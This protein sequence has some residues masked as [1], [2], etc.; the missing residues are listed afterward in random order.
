MKLSCLH[1][2]ALLSQRASGLSRAEGLRLEEH[3]ARCEDCRR[4]ASMLS[5]MRAL[6]QAEEP[7]LSESQRRRVIAAALQ[8][9]TGPI[10]SRAPRHV[11]GAWVWPALAAAAALLLV[12]TF[13]FRSQE[14]QS[15]VARGLPA[16][17]AVPGDRVLSGGVEL[18]G[19][20]VA[21][22][23]PE[24]AAL[25][26]RQGAR[27]ALA[28]ATLELR[29]DTSI[30]WQ[31]KRRSVKLAQ[32]S[33]RV[34]V[35]PAQRRSF[36]VGTE[37]F[38][39]HVLGTSFEVHQRSVRVFR[40]RVQ[41]Q[42]KDGSPAVLLE[43]GARTL[44]ELPPAASSTPVVPQPTA[45]E[46]ARPAGDGAA[47]VDLARTQLAEQRVAQARRTLQRALRSLTAPE[48]RAEAM[49]L[50]AECS[51]VAGKYTEARAAYLRVASRFAQ[52]P[53]AETALFAAARIEAEHGE[54]ARARELLSRYL[55][56]YPRG[57]FA[58]EAQRRLQGLAP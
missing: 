36:E 22:Q 51:L 30:R 50:Q 31:A 14:R 38:T 15:S 52:L 57:S 44:Y 41:V 7:L 28:H 10:S 17:P 54:P 46:P 19:V 23:L 35:D 39:V 32:G 33:V 37:H 25:H 56:R 12:A 21:G 47:L 16:Q 11:S 2:E 49:S 45:A 5:G 40:G 4:T 6:H 26:A 3:L 34:D 18:A 53:A 8:A 13:T 29:P 27:L 9:N 1:G 24:D 58:R 55:A 48:E 43:G 42:P 20:A